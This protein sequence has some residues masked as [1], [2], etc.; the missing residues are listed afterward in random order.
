MFRLILSTLIATAAFG[1]TISIDTASLE[2]NPNAPF[3]LDFQFTDGGGAGADNT[4]TLSDFNLGGGSLT[5]VSS[6]PGV[7][8]DSGPFG[9]EM[10][11]SS[12]FGDAEFTFVPGPTLSF[13][14]SATSNADAGTPDVFALAILDSGFNDLPTTNQNNGIALVEYDFPTTDP[15][16]AA[17]LI[18]SGTVANSDGVTIPAPSVVSSTP[19]P[20]GLFWILTALPILLRLRRSRNA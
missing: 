6:S 12:F 10:T 15:S 19:E 11:D 2:G 9:I 13:N 4:I 8:I 7:T 1:S 5:L 14:L 17:Q 3:T 16:G 18:L 20:A